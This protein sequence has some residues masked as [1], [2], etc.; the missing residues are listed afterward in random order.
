MDPLAAPVA[1]GRAAVVLDKDKKQMELDTVIDIIP[2]ERE[3]QPRIDGVDGRTGGRNFW[4]RLVPGAL[5]KEE[6]RDES[7]ASKKTAAEGM[8]DIALLT[9]NANQLRFLFAY[10]SESSTYYMSVALIIGSL[11]LQILVGVMLIFKVSL[12]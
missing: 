11:V 2:E 12:I 5:A 9:A 6:K 10:N 8:M 4:S 1:L 7:F 3:L